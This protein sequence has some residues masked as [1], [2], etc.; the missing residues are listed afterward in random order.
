MRPVRSP[1]TRES[2]P[3]FG[4]QLWRIVR[5]GRK[6][7]VRIMLAALC[8]LGAAAGSLIMP[9]GLRELLNGAIAGAS[10]SMLRNFALALLGLYTARSILSFIGGFVLRASGE[11]IVADLR[12]RVFAHLHTLSLG[13]FSDHSPGDLTSRLTSDVAAI[14]VAAAEVIPA[15]IVN[16]S[17]LVG[18]LA[19]MTVLNWRL[20][21]LVVLVTPVATLT[22]RVFGSRV[23]TLAR[24]VQDRL[25]QSAII[26]Q[27]TLI[28][29]RVVQAFGA[30]PYEVS[31]YNAVVG[32]L[33]G[34]ARRQLAASAGLTSVVDFIFLAAT[35]AIFWYGGNEVLTGR[36][37]AGDLVAFLFYS[38]MLSQ[39]IGDLSYL[40]GALN[41]STG[42]STR[43]FEL[44]DTVPEIRD[45]IRPRRLAKICGAVALQDVSVQYEGGTMALHRVSLEIHHGEFVALVGPSGAGKTSLMNLIPRFIDPSHGCV[46]LDGCDLRKLALAD[47]RRA[48]ALVP[49]EVQLFAASV[50]D[51]IRYGRFDATDE[52]IEQAAEAA[53]AVEFIRELPLKFDTQVGEAGV[54]LSG[55]ERQR[56]AIARALL[57]NS[58]L[59]LLDEAT[60]SLDPISEGLIQSAIH[61]LHGNRTIIVIAHRMATIRRADRIVVLERGRIQDVGP[62]EALLARGGLYTDFLE[63]APAR[64][65]NL[66]P[67]V[68]AGNDQITAHRGARVVV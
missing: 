48:V 18:A 20:T 1:R 37:S 67:A 61:Q 50:K 53:N 60:A 54:K 59:L 29:V 16:V 35:T 23:Q 39:G 30:V 63:P 31:R 3:S 62:H 5:L 32:E 42:A 24:R 14:R 51:N 55:G 6:Y 58:P 65:C 33:Y 34:E 27:E 47:V 10:R 36:L 11:R 13:F 25:A 22:S 7:R 64:P 68:Q 8:S 15:A 28:A 46:L 4:R 26:V 56:V 12:T 41:A 9:L 21:L 45:P 38:Q 44:L 2:R 17:K 19:L 43:I 66:E 49:Q 57:R 40:Y 52:E